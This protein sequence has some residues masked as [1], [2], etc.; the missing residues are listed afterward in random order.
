MNAGAPAEEAR[1]NDARIVE[2]EEF[3]AVKKIWKLHEEPILKRAGRAI[4]QEKPRTFAA[5]QGSLRDL[6]LRQVIVEFV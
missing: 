4:E 5:V 2:Y 6:I 3:I 1:G